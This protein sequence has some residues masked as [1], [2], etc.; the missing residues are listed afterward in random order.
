MLN[1]IIGCLNRAFLAKKIYS[2]VRHTFPRFTYNHRDAGRQKVDSPRFEP[3][4]PLSRS[5]LRHCRIQWY[6]S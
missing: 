3:S 2:V 5:L 4:G 6:N 1:E